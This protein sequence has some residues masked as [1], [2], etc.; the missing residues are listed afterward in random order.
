M[1][2]DCLKSSKWPDR[3]CR[4]SQPEA[5]AAAVDTF[6]HQGH[7]QKYTDNVRKRKNDF[8][9]ESFV[10]EFIA[11]AGDPDKMNITAIGSSSGFDFS[12][13]ITYRSMGKVRSNSRMSSGFTILKDWLPLTLPLKSKRLFQISGKT[14]LPIEPDLIIDT[15]QLLIIIKKAF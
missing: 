7:S 1:S 15:Y 14:G 9:W 2:E 10:K 13:V 8:T 11:F 4:K 3:L 12:S 6:F 5:V